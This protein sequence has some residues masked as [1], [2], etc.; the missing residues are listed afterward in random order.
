MSVI[1]NDLT[2]EPKATPPNETA[3]AAADKG[4]ASKSGP[5]LQREVDKLRRWSAERS[6]RVW[7]H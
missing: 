3:P 2:I 5:E 1:V 6:L 7:A 4:G